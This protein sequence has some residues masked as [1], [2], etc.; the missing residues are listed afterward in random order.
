MSSSSSHS[1]KRDKRWEDED[2]GAA[3]GNFTLAGSVKLAKHIEEQVKANALS[4]QQ[5]GSKVRNWERSGVIC[6]L[7][8]GLTNN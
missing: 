6:A 4:E 7:F 5:R 3:S 8:M 1:G 2:V